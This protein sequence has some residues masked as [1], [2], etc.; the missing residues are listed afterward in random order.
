[1]V[2]HLIIPKKKSAEKLWKMEDMPESAAAAVAAAAAAAVAVG[3]KRSEGSGGLWH[4]A[5]NQGMGN[6]PV[7]GSSLLADSTP[8]NGS[9]VPF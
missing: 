3:K 6:S 4:P 1:M 2:L 8:A 7:E 9:I 5:Q